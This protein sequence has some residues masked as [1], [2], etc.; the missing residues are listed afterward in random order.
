MSHLD[1]DSDR[2]S[3]GSARDLQ[4]LPDAGLINFANVVGIL[5]RLVTVMLLL[6]ITAALWHIAQ[7]YAKV[8]ATTIEAAR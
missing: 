1:N 7:N 2:A 3:P 5:C 8:H 6:F 4:R